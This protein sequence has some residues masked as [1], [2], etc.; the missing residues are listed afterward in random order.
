MA[1]RYLFADHQILI[2]VGFRNCWPYKGTALTFPLKDPVEGQLTCE[3]DRTQIR[4]FVASIATV[5]GSPIVFDSHPALKAYD[6]RGGD[7]SARAP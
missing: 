1:K 3:A 5:N 7:A 6:L 4:R 2:D